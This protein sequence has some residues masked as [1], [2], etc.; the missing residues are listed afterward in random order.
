MIPDKSDFVWQVSEENRQRIFDWIELHRE[1]E[2]Q[3]LQQLVRIPSVNPWFLETSGPSYEKQVQDAIALKMRSLGASIDQWEPKPEALAKYAGKPGYYPEHR[4]QGRPNQA[5]LIKGSMNGRSL[6]LTGHVDV[7]KAASGWSVDPFEA[8]RKNG[9]VFGRGVL[10]MKGG[11]VAMITAVEAILRCGLQPAGDILVGTVVDEEAG[12]MG[13]LDFIDRGYRA[14]GCIMTEPTDLKIVPMCRGI[15]WGKLILTGR[16][17]HI[18]LPQADWRE[19]GAVDAIQLARL[20]LDGFDRLNQDWARR[21]VHPLLPMPCQIYT[22][23]ISAGEY[24]TAFANRAE[25]VFNAQYLPAERDEH[26]LGGRVKAEIT[27]LVDAIAETD[28]WLK[29]HPPQIEWLIDADCA[30]TPV[31]DPFVQTCMA[32][33][34]K[35]NR[36]AKVEGIGCHTDMGWFVNVGI[37]TINFGAGDPRVAHQNDESLAEDDLVLA[38]QAIAGMVLDWCGAVPKDE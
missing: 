38:T 11:L 5:T 22:A 13:T 23:Q 21:K 29:V 24:P 10:D 14:Q 1:D 27:R 3:F 37:P 33:V 16:S 34:E 8:V 32:A 31:T 30:E 19:G 25:L 9:R 18:E 12:G 15:L 28:P 36:P 4:F 17:G 6:L 2:I 35:L 7:V 20:Y 26:L